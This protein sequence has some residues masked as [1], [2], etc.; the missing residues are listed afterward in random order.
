MGFDFDAERFD[1][2][3]E[4]RRRLGYKLI[5][6]INQYFSSLPDRPVQL[7]LEQRTF[8][9]LTDK[10]PELGLQPEHVLDEV[11]DEL[12]HKGFHVPAANY[13]GLMNP[14]P[15]YVAVLA[16]ALV[17]ALN[18]QLATLA[19]SQLAS[20]IENETV[21]WIGERIWGNGHGNGKP[22][23][24]TFTSGGNEA[25]FS[26]LAL[27][28][29]ARFPQ[30]V[31]DGVASIGARP[32]FYASAEAHHSLDK[33][34]GLLGLGRN[35]LRRVAVNENV[36]M[37]A[38]K[39][40]AMIVADQRAGDIPFCVVSTAGTTNSGAVDDIVALAGL[41]A[42]HGLWLHVDGAYGAA[43]VFSDQHRN[44]VRG[45]E[46]ADS[47]T[48]DPHK[49]LA[50][51]FAAGVIL[52]SRPELL[53]TAFAVATP[54]M[55]NV[56]TTMSAAQAIRGTHLIDNFKVSTQWSRR[57]NSLKFWLTLRVHGRKAYEELIHRQLELARQMREWIERSDAFEMAAPQVLPILN[58]RVQLPGTTMSEADVARANAAVVE[59]VT[60]DGRRWISLTNVNGRSVIRMMIISY[61]TGESHLHDLQQAL[62]VAARTVLKPAGART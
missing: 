7:P 59:E 29:A 19:R 26:A 12:V 4:E 47:V 21:R 50:M 6:H 23:D 28:L 33:S 43:A 34:A 16:E 57:M 14:T 42:K 52:T 13:F 11:C 32:V 8:G 51:P 35:A 60:R 20:K 27:A 48:I 10:M 44:L 38:A 55:P 49:W 45:I 56:G 61:L 40:E 22:F 17:S 31:D 46:R 24:G 9:Q 1:L 36:Q 15:T 3:A 2:N 37:D 39:L 54:Y 53:A 58:F 5:D 18:P 30:A 25:N 62:V 41:C